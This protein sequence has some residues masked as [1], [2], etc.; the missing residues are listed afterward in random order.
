MTP[1][2]SVC[3]CGCTAIADTG[4]TQIIGRTYDI[5]LLMKQLGAT[6]VGGGD[7]VFDCS[8]ITTLP[9]KYKLSYLS[10]IPNTGSSGKF[11][12]EKNS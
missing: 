2:L 8:K 7:Y 4:T 11:S 9:S 12:L 1:G 6:S 5:A 3:S 10:G